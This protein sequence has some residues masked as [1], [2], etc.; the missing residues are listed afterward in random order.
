VT[1][2]QLA[3]LAM[4][5][6]DLAEESVFVRAVALVR[7][8]RIDSDAE[9]GPLLDNPPPDADPDVLKRLRQMYEA[10]GWVLV[11]SALADL[12]SDLRWLYESGAVTIEQLA[13]IH[14]TLGSTSAADLAWAIG[15]Q[16]IRAIPGL[17]ADVEAAITAALP[18]LRTTVPR[19][20]L[21]RAMT[22]AE[23]VLERLRAVPGVAWA[24]PV[25]SLRRGQDTVGD[26]EIVAATSR[27]ADA[28]AEL[29]RDPEFS[30]VLHNTAERLYVLTDRM[31]I[32]VRLPPPENAGATLLYLTGPAA[33]FEALQAHAAA[34]GFRLTAE[35]LQGPD[36]ALLPAADEDAIYG[37]LGLPCIPPEIRDG[38]E[39]IIVASRGEL[40]QLVS[41]A[42]IRGD[43]HMHSLW[44][45][46]RDSIEAMVQGCVALGYEYLAIT[47]HSQSSAAIRNLTADGVRKQADEIAELRD[48][49]PQ[50]A[51]LHGCEVDILPDGRLDFHDRILERFDIVLASLHESAA[52]S[53]DQLLK[54]Y[55]SAMQH[56]LVSVLTHP[57]NRLVPSRR[58]YD[59]DYDRLFA[60]AV[61]YQTAIEIDGAPSHLD[62]DGALARRAIAAGATVVIDSDCH[63]SE[64]LR[65]QMQLGVVTARRGW[66]EPRHVLN[67]RPI[68][69]V[70][71]FIADKRGAR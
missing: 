48:K 15:E 56:P 44:S 63:R 24:T 27:P 23:P 66:V 50:I 12:P 58:G 65:L 69:E 10:G 30:R 71:A 20:P 5:R 2:A 64:T 54:R 31:Q 60:L 19:V 18:T 21:G 41:R 47:D 36:G 14:R 4:I 32:G 49:Y 43:L 13:A 11:E 68:D 57:S 34:R 39:E 16:K 9:A 3:S 33:H 25:G 59:I 46:G 29:L 55:V 53:P 17:N 37:A 26:I 67:A 38:A 40:P 45:D 52:Q 35:G 7:A 8:R 62:L 1:L 51:I 61:E 22:T 6:G 28:I 70:R 42:D